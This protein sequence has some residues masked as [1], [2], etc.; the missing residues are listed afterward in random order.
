MRFIL[1]HLTL[2]MN[3]VAVRVSLTEFSDI[4]DKLMI[5][6]GDGMKVFFSTVL[7]RLLI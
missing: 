4:Y 2:L 7:I 5:N 1:S 6:E 3:A